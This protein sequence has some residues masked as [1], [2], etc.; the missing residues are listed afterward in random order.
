MDVN[1]PR[2]SA[3]RGFEKILRV[4]P[5]LN[6]VVPSS[7]TVGGRGTVSARICLRSDLHSASVAP[8]STGAT[9]NCG[10]PGFDSPF[11]SASALSDAA[12]LSLTRW[13]RFRCRASCSDCFKTRSSSS[14]IDLASTASKS[15][16]SPWFCF[17]NSRNR[18]SA[19]MRRASPSSSFFFFG[20]MAS[21]GSSSSSTS[22]VRSCW[23]RLHGSPRGCLAAAAALPLAAR[24][25]WEPFEAGT[26][27][28]MPRRQRKR[29]AFGPTLQGHVLRER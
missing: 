14:Q 6:K 2:N 22:I 26:R 4:W 5:T 19:K 15:C 18:S 3:W 17:C 29:R 8:R 13:S 9:R 16:N 7:S 21:A 28:P 23:R 11:S 12:S 1:V 20:A 27:F 24:A 25:P 10:S